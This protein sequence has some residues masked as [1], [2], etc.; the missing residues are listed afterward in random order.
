MKLGIASI[1]AL[2]L[3][4]PSTTVLEAK[5]SVQASSMNREPI[6]ETRLTR[7]AS[8]L[9]VGRHIHVIGWE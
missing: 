7:F 1:I 4:E 2:D 3:E 5:A 6:S 8:G 9:T